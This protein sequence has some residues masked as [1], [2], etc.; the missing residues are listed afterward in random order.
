MNAPSP[1][2][3]TR[4]PLGVVPVGVVVDDSPLARTYR[5]PAR[6]VSLA[7]PVGEVNPTVGA[8]FWY[9]LPAAAWAA[10]AWF[11]FLRR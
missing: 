3:V 10:V 7:L 1:Y 9:V 5:M 6:L 11:A 8:F 2:A 4:G